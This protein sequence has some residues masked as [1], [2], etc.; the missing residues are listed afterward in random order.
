[1]GTLLLVATIGRG[2]HIL[3]HHNQTSI[4]E[5]AQDAN[6]A[7]SP[8]T[9]KWKVYR[10]EKYGFQVK[11]PETWAISSS[12]GTPPEIIYFRG[13]YRGVIGQALNV[14]VQLNMNPRKL[15]MEEWFAQQ[16][17]AVDTKKIEAKGC[18]TVAGQPACFFENT[19]KSGKERFVYTLL[20]ETDVLSFDYKIGTEDGP[21]YAAIVDSFQVL[22]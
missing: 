11:Y 10:N 14:T 22:N 4:N 5:S 9:S 20:H 17:R 15:S 2:D 12:R 1:M 16:L 8:D 13:P 19:N 21:S 18:S 3:A 6:S 7:K